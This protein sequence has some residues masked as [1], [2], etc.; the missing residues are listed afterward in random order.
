MYM[1]QFWK[2]TLVEHNDCL[3]SNIL[4]SAIFYRKQTTFG[5]YMYIVGGAL[6]GFPAYHISLASYSKWLEG[7]NL[8][9]IIVCHKATSVGFFFQIRSHL[10]F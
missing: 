1:I 9:E 7:N 2:T 5:I 10:C 4:Y 8:L 3:T 6:T